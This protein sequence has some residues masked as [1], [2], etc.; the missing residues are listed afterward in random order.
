MTG[1]I[2]RIAR[3][4]AHKGSRAAVANGGS[5]AFFSKSVAFLPAH[6]KA[7]R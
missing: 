6:F 5:A 4:G 2:N 1:H 7:E 3:S